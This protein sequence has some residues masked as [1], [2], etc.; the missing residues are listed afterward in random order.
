MNGGKILYNQLK[1][2]KQ[3]AIIYFHSFIFV[4][5]LIENMEIF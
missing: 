5:F 3:E 1:P 2:A 4:F